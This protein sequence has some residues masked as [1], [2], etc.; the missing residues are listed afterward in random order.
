[1]WS[2]EPAKRKGERISVAVKG[3][4]S[5]HNSEALRDCALA[6][7]GIALVPDFSAQREL[8]SGKL[9]SVLPKWRPV[10]GFAERLY[11][12]RPYSPYVPRPVTAFVDYLRESLNEGFSRQ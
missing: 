12:I 9:V 2:F 5:A 4:F 3:S 8:E 1:T 7:L 11:A 6:G 10:G